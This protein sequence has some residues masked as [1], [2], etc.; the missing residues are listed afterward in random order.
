MGKREFLAA[1]RR[2]WK[3]PEWTGEQRGA[4]WGW[5]WGWRGTSGE[6]WQRRRTEAP[7]W[8]DF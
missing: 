8:P 5:G 2:V 1:E 7:G 6:T 3:G 4:G